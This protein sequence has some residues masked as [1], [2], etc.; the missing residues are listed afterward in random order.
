M[1]PER[2][3]SGV[4][5]AKVCESMWVAVTMTPKIIGFSRLVGVGLIIALSSACSSPNTPGS[6]TALKSRLV[7]ASD[8]GSDWSLARAPSYF[9]NQIIF[10]CES[11]CVRPQPRGDGVRESFNSGESSFRETIVWMTNPRPLFDELEHDLR[12]QSP[13]FEPAPRIGP[14]KQFG[15]RLIGSPKP[16]TDSFN[17]F[18][19][20][21]GYL[22]FILCYQCGTNE[23]RA[24]LDQFAS[25]A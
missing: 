15:L 10:G 8:L 2:P 18:V 11:H 13:G 17:Y 7:S 14:L 9:R 16:T 21:G 24:A 6:E 22:G 4:A 5:A 20:A 12:T 25:G 3:V 19:E 23:I 1:R